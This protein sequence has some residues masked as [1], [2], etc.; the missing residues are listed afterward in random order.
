MQVDDWD[1]NDGNEEQKAAATEKSSADHAEST[2]NETTSRDEFSYSLLEAIWTR[3]QMLDPEDEAGLQTY[4]ERVKEM[5]VELLAKNI[6][7]NNQA[8]EILDK[9][10]LDY[11]GLKGELVSKMTT[12][13]RTINFFAQKKFNL[14]REENEG[15]SKLLIELNQENIDGQNVV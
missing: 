12:R 1:Q 7:R 8:Q 10:V 13:Y 9:N 6:V 11:L 3:R 5:Y 4:N 14:M 2:Q 15:F